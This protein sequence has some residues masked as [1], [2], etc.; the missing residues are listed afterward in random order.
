[1]KSKVET[2]KVWQNKNHTNYCLRFFENIKIKCLLFFI[3]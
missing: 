3:F 1:M 2:T